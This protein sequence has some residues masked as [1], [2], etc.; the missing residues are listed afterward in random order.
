MDTPET[1]DSK[2]RVFDQGAEAAEREALR[3]ELKA[4][5]ESITE[6]EK[7]LKA[8]DSEQKPAAERTLEHL[9]RKADWLSQRLDDKS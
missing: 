1:A 2:E 3:D 6:Q 9:Q 7:Q 4:T 5:L 8:A